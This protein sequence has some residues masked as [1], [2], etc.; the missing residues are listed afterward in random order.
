MASDKDQALA[1]LVAKLCRLA[2]LQQAD[3]DAI[4]GLAI[5]TAHVRSHGYLVREG[6]TAVDCCLLLDGYACR[7]KTTSKGGRQIVSFHMPGD[8]LDLQ[9]LLLSRADHDVQTITDA[10]IAWIA[11]ADL[12]QAA[13]DHPLLAEAL[14]RDTLIDASIFREWVLNVGRRSGRAR[15]AHLLCEFAAR[16][17][18]A[19]L[20]PLENL[21]LPMTQEELG[22]ATGLTSVHVNRMLAELQS[23]GLIERKGRKV[24]IVNWARMRHFAEFD[25]TYLHV[26]G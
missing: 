3:T 18:Q 16:R 19:R 21:E 11:A 9:H 4:H 20:G 5:R 26:V 1:L 10:T 12:R 23:L 24:Q 7:S 6:D 8:I 15:I 2:P 13:H 14:W 25:T 22:D 17:E